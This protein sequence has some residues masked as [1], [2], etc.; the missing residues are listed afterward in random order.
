MIDPVAAKGIDNIIPTNILSRAKGL[1]I[2][3]V[4]KAG[5]LFSG[6]AGAGIVVARL[7]DGTWSAP[8]AIGAGGMGFGGQI[9]AEITDFVIVLNTRSAVKSFMKEGN[10]TLGGNLSGEFEFLRFRCGEEEEEDEEE[11]DE[12]ESKGEEMLIGELTLFA[13][14]Q[15][16]FSCVICACVDSCCW[17][18]WKNGGG[19]CFR[20]CWRH[21][22][23][24]LL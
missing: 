2:F 20:D 6:R 4:I 9:G 13:S 16:F 19:G 23:H 11:E 24:L 3:T 10:F 1:A 14:P 15:I 18:D 7:E 8:S 21:C 12:E 17:T 22:R 5:F